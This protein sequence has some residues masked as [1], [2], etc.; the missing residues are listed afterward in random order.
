MW[1]KTSDGSGFELAELRG[2]LWC[3]PEHSICSYRVGLLEHVPTSAKL[4]VDTGAMGGLTLFRALA[5]DAYMTELRATPAETEVTEDTLWV[6]WQPTVSHQ[7]AVRIGYTPLEPNIIDM[8][9]EVIE[10]AYYPDYELLFSHYTASCH[11]DDLIV[12]VG[13][14]TMETVAAH[15]LFLLLPV[16]GMA[17]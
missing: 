14:W 16:A 4:G 3:V 9:V 8:T 11:S 10:H 17:L 2:Q 5:R 13:R 6:S 1:K 7:A 15:P 12:S